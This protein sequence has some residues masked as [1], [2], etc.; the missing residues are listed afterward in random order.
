MADRTPVQAFIYSCPPERVRQVRRVL[1]WHGL[2]SEYEAAHPRSRDP[3]NTVVLGAAYWSAE[4]VL[5]TAADV[6]AE[7]IAGAPE[8]AFLVWEDPKYEYLGEVHAHTPGSDV[9]QA[10]CDAEGR[11]VWNNDAV[12]RMVAEMQAGPDGP[13]A[14]LRCWLGQDVLDCL[15]TSHRA[16]AGEVVHARPCDTCGGTGQ[17]DTRVLGAHGAGANIA[18]ACPAECDDGWATT[19]PSTP[20][21]NEVL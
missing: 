1:A 9:F 13:S 6:A 4:E 10:S 21:G 8:V 18:A 5:G 2:D 3:E 12:M 20:H 14:T 15:N 11:P 19:L 16:R 7:L 17:V